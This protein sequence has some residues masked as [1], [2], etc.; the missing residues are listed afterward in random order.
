MAATPIAP[1]GGG[2]ATPAV[3]PGQ[4]YVGSG[5]CSGTAFTHNQSLF[6]TYSV[7]ASADL[8]NTWLP[9]QAPLVSG[10]VVNAYINYTNSLE[11]F[12]A[13]GNN[14]PD[15][16]ANAANDRQLHV[17]D[18]SSYT[19]TT[20]GLGLRGMI[21][22]SAAGRTRRWSQPG[23]VNEQFSTH[24]MEGWFPFDN[25]TYDA[26]QEDDTA[27]KAIIRYMVEQLIAGGVLNH[28]DNGITRG[29]SSGSAPIPGFNTNLLYI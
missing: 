3:H 17:L 15:G 21:T 11:Q 10:L 14:G 13:S 16:C 24:I 8:K 20:D 2:A 26:I 25:G 28:R 23:D 6:V 27:A 22:T 9:E 19:Q 18:F 29:S 7:S 1:P 12:S 5:I 4:S